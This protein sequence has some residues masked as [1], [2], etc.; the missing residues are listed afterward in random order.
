MDE[1]LN[2]YKILE[3]YRSLM[4]ECMH[5]WK[6]IYTFIHDFQ[7]ISI[8]VDV[9]SSMPPLDIAFCAYQK[10]WEKKIPGR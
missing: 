2:S 3:Q 10:Y 5:Y 9:N 6:N 1:M 4:D 7:V 8:L